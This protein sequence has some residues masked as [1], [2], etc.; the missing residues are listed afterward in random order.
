MEHLTDEDLVRLVDGEFEDG[1]AEAQ[2]HLNA[3]E[4]CRS[5]YYQTGG[6]LSFYDRYHG[7][8]L[9]PSLPPPPKP[10]ADLSQHFDGMSRP[11][12]LKQRRASALPVRWLAVAA[13]VVLGVFVVRRMDQPARV[14]AAELLRRASAAATPS[15]INRRIR[16]QTRSRTFVRPAVMRSLPGSV[17]PEA[18]LRAMFDKARYSWEDPLNV[19]SYIAWREQ[20]D[21]MED[22]VASTP[23]EGQPQLYLVRTSTSDG[24][25]VEATL[26]L[27]AGD[28]HPVQ[29]TLRFAESEVVEISELPEERFAIDQPARPPSVPV[30]PAAPPPAPVGPARELEVVAALHRIGADLGEPVEV[31]R[32]KERILVTV[33]GLDDRRRQQITEALA[34]LDSVEIRL[35][36]PRA[37][38][39]GP[40]RR[41]TVAETSGHPAGAL[42]AELETRLGSRASVDQFVDRALVSSDAVLSRAHALRALA[43]RFPSDVAAS[44]APADRALLGA[45]ARDHTEGLRVR[46]ADLQ[47]TLAAALPDVAPAAQDRLVTPG[48]WQE[49]AQSLFA[50]ARSLDELV[51]SLLAP[52]TAA[53]A[54]RKEDLAP[55]LRGVELQAAILESR[56]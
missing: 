39:A 32:T 12:F 17:D 51:N 4:E 47:S 19:R 42:L 52:G 7:E 54:P 6:Q 35:I 22:E 15:N 10:W 33:T 3:C 29:G 38:A 30:Q 48:A 43:Q 26:A 50:A 16:V 56:L 40:N 21:S 34:G 53:A 37:R 8:I 25:L 31:D 28:L 14:Q 41:G 23:E 5:R 46:F 49:T 24:P 27:R 1:R 20:L 13:A 36:E 2:G 9:K 11:L 55:A 44:M 18:D 45:I